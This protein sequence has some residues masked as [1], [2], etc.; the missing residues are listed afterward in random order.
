MSS[1]T[2]WLKKSFGKYWLFQIILISVLIL[3][4]LFSTISIFYLVNENGLN[5]SSN[6]SDSSSVILT[7]IF[8]S[9]APSKPIT[10][11]SVVNKVRN[12]STLLEFMNT[13]FKINGTSYGKLGYLI[14]EINSIKNDN[15]N[16][17]TYYYFSKDSGWI[18]SSFGVSNFV[19]NKDYQIKWVFGPASS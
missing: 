6:S 19:L 2:N 3:Y 5:P 4:S 13:T 1:K 14:N 9:K 8:D 11:N 18:Y 17:W 15:S 10:W 16:F 7:V 12:G